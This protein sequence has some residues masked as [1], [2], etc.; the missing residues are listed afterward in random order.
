MVLCVCVKIV[1]LETVLV[2]GVEN[3]FDESLDVSHLCGNEWCCNP[4]CLFS[5]DRATNLSRRGCIGYL[6][7]DDKWYGTPIVLMFPSVVL[8]DPSERLAAVHR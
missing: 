6:R 2:S 5:E 1:G 8:S 7:L 3:D 4:V